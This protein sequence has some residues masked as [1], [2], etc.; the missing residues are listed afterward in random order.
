MLRRRTRAD[1]LGHDLEDEVVGPLRSPD[2]R[3][4]VG[5]RGSEHESGE[6]G[7]AKDRRP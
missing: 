6:V 5:L 2:R 7:P 1:H 4:R 3:D